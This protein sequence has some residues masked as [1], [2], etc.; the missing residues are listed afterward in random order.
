M[1]FQFT[2]DRL[3]EQREGEDRE[4]LKGKKDI[5]ESSLELQQRV[6]ESYLLAAESDPQLKIVDCSTDDGKMGSP[7][8]IYSRILKF[9]EG[10]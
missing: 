2:K 4:Y 7:E 10:K 6:R 3:A 5:H 1:P 9:V 8:T